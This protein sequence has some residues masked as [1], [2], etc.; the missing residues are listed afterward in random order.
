MPWCHR[1]MMIEMVLNINSPVE[2]NPLGHQL[3]VIANRQILDQWPK[4]DERS[5][6]TLRRKLLYTTNGQW[7]SSTY[8]SPR[9]YL[10]PMNNTTLNVA[11]I[12]NPWQCL[13]RGPY[14]TKNLDTTPS[15]ACICHWYLGALDVH[16]SHE[17]YHT[18]THRVHIFHPIRTDQ[19]DLIVLFQTKLKFH[20]DGPSQAM[21]I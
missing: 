3:W 21:K 18:A 12:H 11:W 5:H 15:N 19:L 20:S 6:R 7:K 16:K 14:R 1:F 8:T 13:N 10:R 9:I 17:K 4:T 2:S